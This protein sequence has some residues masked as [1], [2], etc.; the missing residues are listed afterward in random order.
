MGRAGLQT[1][2]RTAARWPW[3]RPDG[4]R[5]HKPLRKSETNPS[6]KQTS[7][8]NDLPAACFP[9]L[10]RHLYRQST[11]TPVYDQLELK[12]QIRWVVNLTFTRDTSRSNILQEPT[13]LH[14]GAPSPIPHPPPVL[15][16]IREIGVGTAVTRITG[17][18]WQSSVGCF[19]RLVDVDNIMTIVVAS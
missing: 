16:G 18:G 12:G 4:Q 14:H 13:C 8:P 6:D 2:T 19:S 10:Q 15:L 9:S 11:R 5:R 7:H 3:R 17:R 1:S